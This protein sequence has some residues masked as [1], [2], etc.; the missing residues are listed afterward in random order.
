V[1]RR[2]IL[3]WLVLV[4][5]P[6][7]ADAFCGFFIGRAETQLLNDTTHVVLMREGQ[8]T[9]MSMQ[10]NYRGPAED[11]AMVVPVPVVL[12][13]TNVR[14]LSREV[15]DRVDQVT[16]PRL[17]EYW[18][19]DPCWQPPARD[20]SDSTAGATM[21][22]AG[23]PTRPAARPLVRVEASFA[24]GE[25]EVLVLGADDSLALDSWL[26]DHGYRIPDGAEP[27]LRPYVAQGMHFFV[28]KVNVAKVRFAGNEAQLSPLRFHFD[29]DEF[30]LPIRLGLI[31]S[32]GTQDLLVHI[33]A[34]DRYEVANYPSA[35]IPTNLDVTET[36]AAAFGSFYDALL[37]RTFEQHTNAVVTEYAWM[38]GTCDPCT[39]PALTESEILT[40]GANVIRTVRPDNSV[41]TRLHA[42]YA[43]DAIGEDLVFRVAKPIVGGREGGR[44][45][46]LEH[47][48]TPASYN[49]FQARYAIRHRWPGPI[50]CRSPQRGHWIEIPH[51]RSQ[52]GRKTVGAT[53][54]TQVHGAEL[55]TFLVHDV[56]EINIQLRTPT[57]AY[58]G[59][60][61]PRG[62]CAACHVS[63]QKRDPSPLWLFV[64]LGSLAMRR[65][66]E[67]KH[68]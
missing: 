8:R 61:P 3:A 22:A 55:E 23:S 28:A 49:A 48:A 45:G 4:A 2:L 66:P 67:Q 21:S 37:S 47:A 54:A 50:E 39:G 26:K 63:V 16:S 65:A 24:V 33:I 44:D 7:E 60:P 27:V 43:K 13:A 18:E 64:V 62:G 29:S 41:L 59:A 58:A 1:A 10:N 51:D 25:Y 56:P 31:N 68:D 20:D 15:F 40:L 36:T 30:V 14:T 35:T 9:V 17:V 42:R 52:R 12:Q 46:R 11:F 5:L 6:A 34:K 53:R 38:A 19:R 57:R 32:S